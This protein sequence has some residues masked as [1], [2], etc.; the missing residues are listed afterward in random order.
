M[1]S[2]F[3]YNWQVREEWMAWCE[4]LPKEELMKERTGG[5]KGILTTFVHIIDVEYSWIYG[6]KGIDVKE[7]TLE[8]YDTLEKI[9]E[10]S[11]RTKQEL[12]SIIEEEIKESLAESIKVSWH[13]QLYTRG[14][15]IRH[16]IAHEIHH[17]GQLSVWARDLN[18][19][20]ISPN[21]IGRELLD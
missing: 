17:I 13:E 3:L 4:T 21:F 1:M 14:E 6:L 15:I 11:N 5:V 18:K 16:V 7:F 20:P 19:Q 8:E 12:R 9:I 10:L 2:F